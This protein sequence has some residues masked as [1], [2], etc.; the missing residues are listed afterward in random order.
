[1]DRIGRYRIVGEVGRGAMGV[2]YRAKDPPI[3]RDVA[4][5]TV[6]LDA[7]GE[8]REKLRE[9]LFR[10]ARSAGVLSHPNI[11]TIY[12]MGEEDGLAYIA[13][14]LVRGPSLEALLRSPTAMTG[15]RMLSIL[16]QTAV[17]LDYAHSRG[18]VHRDI[19]PG[20]I[21]TDEDGAVKI[22]DFGIARFAAAERLNDTRTITGTPNYMSPE[23]IQGVEADGRTDQFSLGVVTWEI[24]TGEKPFP[25][26]NLSTVVYR[27]VS[28]DPLPAYHLNGTLTPRID[29]VLQRVLA[30]DPAKRF[31]NC[32][33]FVGALEM[34]CAESP[35]WT[36]MPAGAAATQ[37]TVGAEWAYPQPAPVETPPVSIPQLAPDPVRHSSAWKWM[38]AVALVTALGGVGWWQWSEGSPVQQ[39]TPPAAQ[40][41]PQAPPKP[42]PMVDIPRVVHSEPIPEV[43]EVPNPEPKETARPTPPVQ[44]YGPLQ[45]VRIDSAPPGAHAVLDGN[46]GLSCET[47][48]V[49]HARPGI[50][51]VNLSLPGY[52]NE[53]RELHV[54]TS[55]LEM[56]TVQ[57]QQATGTLMLSSAPSGAAVFL[58]GTRLQQVTPTEITLKP[59]TY[60]LLIEKDGLRRTE[61]VQIRENTEY[62]KVTLGQ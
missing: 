7:V 52:R 1:M 30:K 47:P 12:D 19:K 51:H 32:A 61:T 62:L 10:E 54:Q 57:L 37:P 15:S 58:N 59:G 36:P 3:G 18:V 9:R 2:V 23:Q 56:A 21:M 33:S 60:T 4:I 29:E 41:T 45:D 24:L 20:N 35:G 5:K 17:A 44:P 28:E 49:L 22:T 13:M 11:V 25:G 34:A 50:H 39:A 27:I 42:V 46:T 40:P 38:A 6:R 48:C 55:T 43:H 8:A 31:A 14:G 16:R 53:Y 26:E